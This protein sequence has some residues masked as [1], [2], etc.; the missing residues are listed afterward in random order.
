LLNFWKFIYYL[1]QNFNKYYRIKIWSIRP[2]GLNF[3]FANLWIQ[4]CDNLD[5]HKLS[6]KDNKIVCVS[7][8]KTLPTKKFKIKETTV[9]VK[10][11]ILINYITIR[12]WIHSKTMIFLFL[13]LITQILVWT[14]HNVHNHYVLQLIFFLFP[15]GR[16]FD[17]R[18]KG[19]F[20]PTFMCKIIILR[21]KKQ[22]SIGNLLWL[23][24]QV[25]TILNFLCPL[26]IL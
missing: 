23:C 20:F 13:L 25:A 18:K 9:E 2:L 14:C 11:C 22:L 7:F 12:C 24:L 4:D 3:R 6:H 26:S 8:I 19:F 15:L 1:C 17:N 21:G 5:T 10:I 16:S